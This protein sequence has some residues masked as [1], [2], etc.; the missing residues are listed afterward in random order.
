MPIIT[1]SCFW[2]PASQQNNVFTQQFIYLVKYT[3]YINFFINTYTAVKYLFC[4]IFFFHYNTI[5]GNYGIDYHNMRI[6]RRNV[7][8]VNRQQPNSLLELLQNMTIQ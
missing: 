2:Q 1:H 3:I 8:M 4:A 7:L 5:L 6:E